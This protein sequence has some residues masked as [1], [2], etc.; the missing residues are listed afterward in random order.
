MVKLPG[1]QTLYAVT[2]HTWPPVEKH[3]CGPFTLRKGM[4]GGSRVSAATANGPFKTSDIQTSASAMR[5]MNQ[6]PL[7]MIREDDAPLDEMLHDLGYAIK[8]P[9]TLYAARVS[10]TT[11]TRPPHKSVFT[12]W[13]PLATQVEIWTSGDIGAG[14]IAAMERAEMP[15]TTLLGRVNDR[16]AGTCYV[17][18]SQ[19]CAM[20]HALEVQSHFR[21]QGLARHMMHAA[22][23][24]ARDHNADF[25][26]LLT[27]S[28]NKSANALYTSLGMTVVGHY[29]Y[30]ILPE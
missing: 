15:K 17:G 13:P 27:G 6:A 28:E 16:P 26:T 20:V 9:V 8:D 11:A 4:N 18:L 12:A 1:A 23:F 7:F 22:A 29:H 19:G 21:R 30:R 24:W 10:D 25:L 3:I 14:R 5:N 2:D